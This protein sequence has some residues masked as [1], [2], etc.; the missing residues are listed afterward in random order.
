MK[1]DLNLSHASITLSEQRV[2]VTF[3]LMSVHTIFSSVCVAEW[4]SFGKELPIQVTIYVLIV[5]R[6]LVTLDISRFGFEGGML[7]FD[8]SSSWPLHTCFNN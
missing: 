6:L 2:S 5:F 4:P 1:I 7:G 3:Q 8:C